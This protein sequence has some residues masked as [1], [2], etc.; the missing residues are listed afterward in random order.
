MISDDK[1]N[2]SIVPVDI[3]EKGYGLLSMGVVSTYFDALAFSY[4][5]VRNEKAKMLG[6]YLD[7]E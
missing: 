7:M 4:G 3:Q 6:L 2:A 5:D 1:K